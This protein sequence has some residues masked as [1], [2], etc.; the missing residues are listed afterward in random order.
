MWSVRYIEIKL[1]AFP[2]VLIVKTRV[3]LIQEIRFAF[4]LNRNLCGLYKFLPLRNLSRSNQAM[5]P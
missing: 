2:D 5:E 3:F 4:F 1:N